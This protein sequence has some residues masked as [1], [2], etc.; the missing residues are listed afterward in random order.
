[1]AQ[2]GSA[3]AAV[4][5]GA[6]LAGCSTV[7]SE[8][9]FDA[10]R[11]WHRQ[12]QRAAE[13]G[14][15]AEAA[16]LY[17]QAIAE[18]PKFSQ[19]YHDRGYCNVQLRL[20]PETEGNS[21]VYLEQAFKDFDTS[22]R[23]NPAYGNAFFNRAMLLASVGRHKEAAEDL[24]NVVRLNNRDKQ[25]H[26]KLGELYENKFENAVALAMKHYDAYVALGGSDLKVREKVRAWR[27]LTDA[28]A[29]GAPAEE[30]QSPVRDVEEEA[31][32][33]HARAMQFLKDGRREE[34]L[35]GIEK[36]LAEYGGTRFVSGQERAFKAL[37]KSLR[38]P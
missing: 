23:I 34:G 5:L 14:D 17:T 35:N 20:D 26:L 15:Y 37:L 32:A 33:L 21:K 36:L 38:K 19:A 28:V 9:D 12:G 7:G 8:P 16:S 18:H 30:P 6:F 29:G 4:F 13:K 2:R 24:L 27:E 22:I 3:V 10:A 31:K 11:E 1:V 25:A